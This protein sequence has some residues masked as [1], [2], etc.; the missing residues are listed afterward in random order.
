MAFSPQPKPN[1]PL[2]LAR[3][4][5]RLAHDQALDASILTA[6]RRDGHQCRW[7]RCEFRRVV[8]PIDGAQF[9]EAKG[10]GGDPS[11]VR[12]SPDLLMALCRM[13]H[14]LQE[15]GEL[16]VEPLTDAMAD[17]PCAFWSQRFNE[18]RYLVA[19]E[20]AIGLLERD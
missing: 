15:H 12:S 10:M 18:P 7:P 9:F 4:Q 20:R 8:Q 6:K 17:G 3:H 14:D 11:L 16:K 13:H 19:Q 5:R 2:R 1:V